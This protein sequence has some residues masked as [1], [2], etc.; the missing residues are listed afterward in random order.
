MPTNIE[1]YETLRRH[2]DEEVARVL[3]EAFPPREDLTTKGDIERLELANRADIERLRQATHA[4]VERL[5]QARRAD[6]ERLEQS[7][8]AEIKRLEASTYRW[9]LTFFATQWLGVIGIIVTILATA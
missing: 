1:L 6:V 4:D 5:E 8:R 7:T 9:M 2:M 3:A